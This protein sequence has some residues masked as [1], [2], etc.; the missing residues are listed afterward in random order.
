MGTE[1][2]SDS[3]T[4][5]AEGLAVPAVVPADVL[6]YARPITLD[7]A[8]PIADRPANCRVLYTE[9]DDGVR[10]D[11]PPRGYG[12]AVVNVVLMI[13]LL[14][15]AGVA[16]YDFFDAQPKYRRPTGL[17]FPCL[18]IVGA[19][20]AGMSARMA[21][22][23]GTV[24]VAQGGMLMVELPRFFWR[25]RWWRADELWS[26]RSTLPSTSLVPPGLICDLLVQPR[27]RLGVRVLTRRNMA[28]VL[29]VVQKLRRALGMRAF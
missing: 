25:Q 4:A 14:V 2:T 11:D 17:I 3:N 12:A 10:F 18:L 29:W 22:S 24:I 27:W 19:A 5:A 23:R 21:A 20:A 26:I 8:D 28:E 13:V 1:S 16:V 9:L 7:Y 15:A 6:N